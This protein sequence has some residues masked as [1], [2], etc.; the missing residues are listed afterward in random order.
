MVLISKFVP[1]AMRLVRAASSG[2][3]LDV[4]SAKLA[5][6]GVVLLFAL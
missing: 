1:D 4:Y 5:G 2:T 3:E 6:E